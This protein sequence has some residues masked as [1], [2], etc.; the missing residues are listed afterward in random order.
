MQ[1][2]NNNTIR[3]NNISDTVGSSSSDG[4]NVCVHGV[5]EVGCRRLVWGVYLDG[6]EAGIT[7]H[8][9]IIGAT[10]HGA[11][12]DN[13]GG[14][15]TQT[16]NV[17]VAGPESEILMD[18]G[19]PGGGL[20]NVSGNVVKRNIFYWHGQ[21]AG[22]RSMFG[23]QVG[24]SAAFLKPNGSDGNLFF[25]SAEDAKTAKVFPGATTL[26][27]W[28]GR[29]KTVEGPVSCSN[30]AGEQGSMIVSSNCS[31][32]FDHN[33]TT[34]MYTSRR[35]RVADND[36]YTIDLDCDGNWANCDTGTTSTRVCLSHYNGDWAPIIPG[37]NPGQVQN[38]AWNWSSTTGAIVN[39]PNGKCIEVCERGGD[40]GGC[41]VRDHQPTLL[42]CISTCFF[43]FLS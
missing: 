33:A 9:N 37:K 28:S 10:L 5:P 4:K 41:N 25:S 27:E 11:V 29:S 34:Q 15:N 6:G 14:N 40:V 3:F 19:A 8:G 20:R 38:N 1:W 43:G 18:F 7:I 2:W 23:S 39:E 21:S 16:N 26:S 32:G 22:S 12:F 13:A 31:W 24:W 17:F 30:T 36:S 35:F 42:A